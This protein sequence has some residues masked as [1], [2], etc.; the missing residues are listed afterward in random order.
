MSF[1]CNAC[2]HNEFW[3]RGEEE[4]VWY[5]DGKGVI[6]EYGEIYGS[7]LMPNLPIYCVSCNKAF[8]NIPPEKDA[9]KEWLKLKEMDSVRQVSTV[10]PICGDKNPVIDVSHSLAGSIVREKWCIECNANWSEEFTMSKV[11]IMNCKEKYIPEEL[12]SPKI[13][14]PNLAFV[15]GEN[16]DEL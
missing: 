9:I 5:I 16:K 13:P 12:K 4:T 8:S 1:V 11:T 7:N 6:T 10:C 2:G 15:K 3:T 14:D